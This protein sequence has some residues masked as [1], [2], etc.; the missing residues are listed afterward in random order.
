MR[1][2]HKSTRSSTIHPRRNTPSVSPTLV[3]RVLMPRYNQPV[4]RRL[5]R[6]SCPSRSECRCRERCQPPLVQEPCEPT[7]QRNSVWHTF[8]Y[9][10]VGCLTS[11]GPQPH[12]FRSTAMTKAIC[13]LCWGRSSRSSPYSHRPRCR[14]GRA[15]HRADTAWLA[16]LDR[17]PDELRR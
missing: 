16:P 14:R 2:L 13:V 11:C 6:S 5:G 9:L 4:G 8:G 1:N 12:L 10:A 15:S 7:R 17:V 3:T